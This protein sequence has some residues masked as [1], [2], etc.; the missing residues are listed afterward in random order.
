MVRGTWVFLTSGAL[1]KGGLGVW[2]KLAL[3]LVFPFVLDTW[4]IQSFLL[5]YYFDVIKWHY[6]D[7]EVASLASLLA[8][9]LSLGHCDED[10]YWVSI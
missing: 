5:L 1:W 2:V 10:V 4:C 9:L 6:H 8:S 7:Q 3:A